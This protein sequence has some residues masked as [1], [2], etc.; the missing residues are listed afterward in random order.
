MNLPKTKEKVE[1]ELNLT[2]EELKKTDTKDLRNYNSELKY[3]YQESEALML[4]F[5]NSKSIPAHIE[6]HKVDLEKQIDKIKEILVEREDGTKKTAITKKEISFTLNQKFEILRKMGYINLIAG[7]FEDKVQHQ[8]FSELF[9]CSI[10]TSRKIHSGSYKK[11]K[12]ARPLDFKGL[13]NK[14]KPD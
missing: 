11:T 10:D 1:L 8:I 5:K 3:N 6:M 2:L 14:I 4:K 9:N 13:L 7:K 12:D